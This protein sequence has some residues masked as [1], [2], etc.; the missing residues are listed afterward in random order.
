MTPNPIFY[1]SLKNKNKK[2]KSILPTLIFYFVIPFINVHF[3]DSQ[4]ILQKNLICYHKKSYGKE[5]KN[6]IKILL[7]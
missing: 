7:P 6:K 1:F 4:T 3:P 2:I 5:G